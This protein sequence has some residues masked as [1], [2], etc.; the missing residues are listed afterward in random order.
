MTRFHCAHA[1]LPGG[2]ADDVLVEVA[3]GRFVGVRAGIPVD[4]TEAEGAVRLAGVTLPGLANAHSH[5]FHRA[6]RGRTQRERGTFWTWRE[7]M[8][9]VAGA[10]DPDSYHALAT[11]VYGEMALAGIT[12]VGEFHYLHHGPGGVRYADPNA[13]SEALI[14]AAADAGI[15]I[16]LLDTLYLTAGVGGE[17]LQG[18][19]L[20]FGDGSFEGWSSRLDRLRGRPHVRLG[21]AA[22]SVRAV[23]A[24]V[25]AAFAERTD[26][27]PTHVHLSE[28]R[29][30]NEAC[31]AVH[32][33]TPTELLADHGLLGGRVTAVH[34][35]HLSDTDRTELGDSGTGVCFCPTT[36]RDLAD[37]IGHARAL[38]EAGSPLSLGSDSHA[39]IDLF[40]EARGV[41]MHERL[42]TEHRGHF[43]AGELI[44]AATVAG[45]AALGWPHAGSIAVGARA[46]LVSVA[47]DSP[48]TAGCEPAA[49]A[50]AATAAD[51]RHVVVD[52]RVVVRDGVHLAIGDVG[53]ALAE[54]I[55]MLSDRATNAERI[56]ATR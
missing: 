37:G 15:R 31:L 24:E 3:G 46:D 8:Y 48:R 1:W 33:R 27:M 43:T 50:F 47:L 14:A 10:L 54:A 11:A 36:E 20:R 55:A 45:H 40:E 49:I 2:V 12:C 35:T 30:E 18:V 51:V 16:T 23:P 53:A 7:Q 34:A 56:G 39:V 13:M 17:A 6:L 22:H 9:A 29:A 4:A 25:L 5:A 19:Q 52:G 32:G 21:A 44:D 38:V 41:E 28:Q 26:G 42:H